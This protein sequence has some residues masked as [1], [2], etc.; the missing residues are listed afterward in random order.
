MV[1]PAWIMA[2]TTKAPIHPPTI[3]NFVTDWKIPPVNR[4]SGVVLFT[5]KYTLWS[6]F[7]ATTDTGAR[8]KR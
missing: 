3:H 1:H 4:P 5:T 6:I 8:N 2:M 7:S